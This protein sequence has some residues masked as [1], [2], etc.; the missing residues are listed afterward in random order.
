MSLG[1]MPQGA[2]SATIN[3]MLQAGSAGQSAGAQMWLCSWLPCLDYKTFTTPSDMMQWKADKKIVPG[4]EAMKFLPCIAP[5]F[6]AKIFGEIFKG[7]DLE[8]WAA[9]LSPEQ[10]EAL[11]AART[12][13][14][15]GG[16]DMRA[17]LGNLSSMNNVAMNDVSSP[18]MS[19]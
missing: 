3:S 13:G 8:N 18:G 2:S 12:Q 15:E 11:M 1:E 14:I 6:L 5:G 9:D 16:M 7:F 4:A 17:F 19:V 10:I